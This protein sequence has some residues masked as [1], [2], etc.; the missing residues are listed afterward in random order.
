MSTGRTTA[1][2]PDGETNGFPHY[3][4]LYSTG[5]CGMDKTERKIVVPMWWHCLRLEIHGRLVDS[6]V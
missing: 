2:A 1:S 3:A 6:K 5:Q 4:S